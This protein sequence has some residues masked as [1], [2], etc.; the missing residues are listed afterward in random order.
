MNTFYRQY[1]HLEEL[2]SLHTTVL[3]LHDK[4]VLSMLS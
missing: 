2:V 4:A 3:L 1:K